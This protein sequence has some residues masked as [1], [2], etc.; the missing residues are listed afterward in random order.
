VN[1]PRVNTTRATLVIR[2]RRERDSVPRA[3][4]HD[5]DDDQEPGEPL[6]GPPAQPWDD[7]PRA[8]WSAD[9]LTS[10]GGGWRN[11]EP[12]LVLRGSCPVCGH[13]GISE[14]LPLHP[15]AIGAGGEFDEAGVAEGAAPAPAPAPG[16][17]SAHL[18][19][20]RLAGAVAAEVLREQVGA[21]REAA[22]PAR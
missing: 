2:D 3:R 4:G 8:R 18:V 15:I 11:A 20:Q 14:W 9:V 1:Y 7:M 16:L 21:A 6:P 22:V 17:R 10:C 12:R 5:G 19:E 13:Y